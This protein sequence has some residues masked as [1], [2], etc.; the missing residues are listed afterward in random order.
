MLQG[1]LFCDRITQME[2]W[3]EKNTVKTFLP[4]CP[5][6]HISETQECEKKAVSSKSSGL[7][8]C[9]VLMPFSK[10]KKKIQAFMIIPRTTLG[11]RCCQWLHPSKE[12]KYSVF[13]FHTLRKHS[14]P[15]AMSR[16]LWSSVC[17]EK[18]NEHYLLCHK[19]MHPHYFN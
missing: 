13:T 10:V 8:P 1:L 18:A 3:M 14:N 16:V 15:L 6:S 2:G 11:C 17:N 5:T 4:E 7:L 9:C 19:A 12:S